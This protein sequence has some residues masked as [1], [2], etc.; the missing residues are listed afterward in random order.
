MVELEATSVASS[1]LEGAS[2]ELLVRGRSEKR[3]VSRF[4]EEK[5]ER[6]RTDETADEAAATEVDDEA[7]ELVDDEAA[8]SVVALTGSVVRVQPSVKGQTIWVKSS[9]LSGST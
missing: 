1:A 3:D 7:T 9:A 5:G 4:E 8:Y 2:E 6:R